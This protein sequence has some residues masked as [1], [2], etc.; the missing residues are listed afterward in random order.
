MVLARHAIVAWLWKRFIAFTDRQRVFMKRR[1]PGLQDRWASVVNSLQEVIPS[2]E[3]ASSMI[4]I[5]ADR[6]L[7]ATCVAF[8]VE[9]GYLVL[10]LGAGPGVMSRLVAAKGG[11]PVLLDVSQAMLAASRFPNRVRAIFE[12]LPFREG[13]FDAVVSGFALRDAIDLPRAIGQLSRALKPRGKLGFCDLGKPDSAVASLVVALYLRLVPI[14]VGLATTGVAGL[15]YGSIY[16]TYVLVLR[17]SELKALLSNH[18]ESV[19]IEK[20]QFGGSI[21]AKCVNRAR[22]SSTAR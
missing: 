18:F 14:I 13:V 1:R 20:T 4:S 16:D 2:Y 3:E 7:R 17:N 15:R 10:D 12:F 8:A 11:E 19:E 6:R 21:V 9:R 5:H 22:P